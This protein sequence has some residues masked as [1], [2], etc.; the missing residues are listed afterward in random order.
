MPV[1]ETAIHEN[2]CLVLRKD[3]VGFPGEVF[4]VETKPVSKSMKNRTDDDFGTGILTFNSRH[5]PA[6][7]GTRYTICQRRILRTKPGKTSAFIAINRDVFSL[8]YK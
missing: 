5:V 1:P 7:A 8:T 6:S 4:S 2:N 3:D